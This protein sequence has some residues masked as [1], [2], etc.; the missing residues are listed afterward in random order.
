MCTARLMRS[1]RNWSIPSSS[2]S[3]WAYGGSTIF[4]YSYSSRISGSGIQSAGALRTSSMSVP[5]NITQM[6]SLADSKGTLSFSALML[7]WEKK[8]V[9]PVNADC[10]I[11][12]HRS[13]TV[14][15]LWGPLPERY[16]I[17]ISARAKRNP[18][19]LPRVRR[20]WRKYGHSR[21]AKRPLANAY[22]G[23]FGTGCRNAL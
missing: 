21:P 10:I 20:G 1:S 14:C 12:F 22:I 7:P 5:V 19:V 17:C 8:V 2:R 16:S 23:I 4:K 15:S 11:D 3:A 6:P 9:L 18:R 13:P